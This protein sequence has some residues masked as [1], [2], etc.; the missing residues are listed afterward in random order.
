MLLRYLACLALRDA[1]RALTLPELIAEVERPGWRIAGQPNK[2][3]A[4][5]L[6]WDV[7]SGRVARV[8]RG[9]YAI[10]RVPKSTIWWMRKETARIR[11]ELFAPTLAHPPTR[12]P[13]GRMDAISIE[14]SR[15]NGAIC[16]E[17]LATLPTWFGIPEANQAYVDAADVK[18]NFV[19]FRAT[20]DAV[21][22]LTITRFGEFAAEIHLIAV[23]ADLHR[24]GVGRMMLG[25]AEEWLRDD[26]VEYLQVKTLSASS[27]DPGYAKT[28]EFY[29]GVGFRELEE[30][31][32]LWD[33]SSPA[34]QMIKRL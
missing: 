16:A 5:A 33:P 14:R 26:G 4:D 13:S 6:R 9:R 15:G 10:D 34:L 19:A 27:P 22:I 29:R 18:T 2:T 11:S 1:E 30:F 12:E 32:T 25:A 3:L 23:V 24:R 21:G 20:A 17:I 7:R 28:R 8:G 31:P